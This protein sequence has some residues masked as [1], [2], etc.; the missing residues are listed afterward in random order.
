M[1]DL[2]GRILPLRPTSLPVRWSLTTLYSTYLI[3]SCCGL[4]VVG[5]P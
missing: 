5:E 3:L 4:K 1:V 2:D